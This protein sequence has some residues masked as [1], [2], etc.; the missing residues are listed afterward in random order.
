MHI[1]YRAQFVKMGFFRASSWAHSQGTFRV[2]ALGPKPRFWSTAKELQGT[3]L[4]QY[5]GISTTVTVVGSGV[6]N[7]RPFDNVR[8]I[9]NR[10]NQSKNDWTRARNSEFINC[11]S[12]FSTTLMDPDLGPTPGSGQRSAVGDSSTVS[13]DRKC[14]LW[15]QH[16]TSLDS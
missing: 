2:R 9:W 4:Y 7:S 6:L 1:A 12:G 3:I 16:H 8:L 10:L 13:S 14:C 11:Q 15:L 5:H